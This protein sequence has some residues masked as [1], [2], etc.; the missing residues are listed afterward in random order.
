MSLK[1]NTILNSVFYLIF[2]LHLLILSIKLSTNTATPS[3]SSLQAKGTKS[4]SF[5]ICIR[6]EVDLVPLASEDAP[7]WDYVHLAGYS[8]LKASLSWTPPEYHPTP[9]EY[10][11]SNGMV[12]NMWH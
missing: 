9:P 11:P 10:H 5:L 1:V 2:G 8:P 6:N 12:D 7:H 4:T 3:Y